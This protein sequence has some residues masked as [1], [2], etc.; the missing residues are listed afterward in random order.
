MCIVLG[1]QFSAADVYCRSEREHRFSAAT[2]LYG[3]KCSR[4]WRVWNCLLWNSKAR[5]QTSKLVEFRNYE[6]N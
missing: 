4:D 2:W 6:N 5:Q 1:Y 3:W